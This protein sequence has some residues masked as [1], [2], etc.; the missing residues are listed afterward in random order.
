MKQEQESKYSLTYW[1]EHAH[2]AYLAVKPCS[3][4]QYESHIVISIQHLT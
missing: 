2:R 1:V 3:L 4:R